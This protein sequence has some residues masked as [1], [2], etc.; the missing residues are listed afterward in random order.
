M[1]AQNTNEVIPDNSVSIVET[2]NPDAPQ[3]SFKT[4]FSTIYY[5]N[6]TDLDD[7]IWRLGG[8][9]LEYTSDPQLA[10]NRVDKL[11]NRVQMI[12][13]MWPKDF[14]I[15]IYLHRGTLKPNETAYYESKTNSIHI[16]VDYTSDGVMAHELAH[17]SID[18]YFPTPPPTKMQEILAQYVDKQLWSNY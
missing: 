1:L 6:D 13:D 10:S 9:K 11:V 2:T 16:S 8:Q 15:D 7:F 4:K 12:L 17:A 14:Q 3:K 5:T 18:H